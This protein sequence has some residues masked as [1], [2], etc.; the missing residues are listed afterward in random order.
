LG[1]FFILYLD[2]LVIR[3]FPIV[4]FSLLPQQSLAVQ[5]LPYRMPDA[6]AE[7][8]SLAASWAG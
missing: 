2:I 4:R 6:A 3:R 8:I 1:F 5:V 7:K